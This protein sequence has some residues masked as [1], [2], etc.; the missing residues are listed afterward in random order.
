[1]KWRQEVGIFLRC[2]LRVEKTKQGKANQGYL[3][4]KSLLDHESIVNTFAIQDMKNAYKVVWFR[5][6]QDFNLWVIRS[7]KSQAPN[8]SWEHDL[9]GWLREW[10]F[11]HAL[12][13][14][15]ERM[16]HVTNMHT[17]A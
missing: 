8:M 11:T 3:H 4:R 16:K 2:H 7:N 5:N 10:G 6:I 1:M 15:I 17:R 14:V 9:W 13:P 12:D